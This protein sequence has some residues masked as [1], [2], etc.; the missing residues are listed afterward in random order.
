MVVV[1]LVAAVKV[2]VFAVALEE[3]VMAGVAAVVV[4]VTV[5]VYVYVCFI[6]IWRDI[7]LYRY[8]VQLKP[9]YKLNNK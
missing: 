9:N 2:V 6:Q 7:A 4:L 5:Y 8:I 3:V 1:L